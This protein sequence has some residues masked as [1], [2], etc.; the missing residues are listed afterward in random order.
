MRIPVVKHLY[1]V[2]LIK[3]TI[4]NSIDYNVKPEEAEAIRDYKLKSSIILAFNPRSVKPEGRLDILRGIKGKV[5]LLTI[6][7]KA[8]IENVLVDTAVLDVP[9]IG[10]A[11][12]A[13]Q[14]VK[15]EFGLPAG[16]S[17]S[18]AL[19]AWKKAKEELGRLALNVC[20]ASA[21]AIPITMGADFILYGPIEWADLAF[22]VCAMTDAI[23]AYNAWKYGVKP[24][25]K[26]HPIF[27][28]L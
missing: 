16:C 15:E 23:I 1:E 13:I 14:L 4:Y 17:P 8:G 2:G 26:D 7:K 9:S 25:T 19:G 6:A 28:I 12:K 21:N 10:I 5:G 27:K 3:R 22:P 18:N 24:L 20:E 11:A